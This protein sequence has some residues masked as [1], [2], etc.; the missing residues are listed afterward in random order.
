MAYIWQ[1]GK[2]EL[3]ATEDGWQSLH[4]G[5]HSNHEADGLEVAS[6]YYYRVAAITANGITEF[7]DPVVKLVV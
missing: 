1:F 6:Y 5:T 3:P 2:G 7:F 4:I